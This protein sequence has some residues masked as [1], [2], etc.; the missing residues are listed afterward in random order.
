MKELYE[1]VKEEVMNKY[2]SVKEKI[3]DWIFDN[4]SEFILE[5]VIEEFYIYDYP[6]TL[7]WTKE[8]VKA[9]ENKIKSVKKNYEHVEADYILDSDNTFIWYKVVTYSLVDEEKVKE[10]IDENF[11][12]ELVR[13]LY[14]KS[15]QKYLVKSITKNLAKMILNWEIDEDS[16]IKVLYS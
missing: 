1:S 2:Q 14:D 7:K 4:Y 10:F 8:F 5:K 6:Y 9:V 12:K 11:R 3:N 13:Y 16:V 15:W